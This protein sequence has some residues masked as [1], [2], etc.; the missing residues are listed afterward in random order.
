M[1]IKMFRIRI[2]RALERLQGYCLTN[3]HK[4]V[5]AFHSH[6]IEWDDWWD[7]DP[8]FDCPALRIVDAL[9]PIRRW[10]VPV[11]ACYGGDQERFDSFFRGN[12]DQMMFR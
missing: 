1:L 9:Y 7:Q 10:I 2:D 8:R 12:Y 4:Q 6:Q 3:A 11:N 5:F